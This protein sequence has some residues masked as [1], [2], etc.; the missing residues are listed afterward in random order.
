M[1]ARNKKVIWHSN[2]IKVVKVRISERRKVKIYLNEIQDE[3]VPSSIRRGK[4]EKD[5]DRTET[6][7]PARVQFQQVALNLSD[8][9]MDAPIDTGSEMEALAGFELSDKGALEDTQRPVTLI[10]AGRRRIKGGN[11]DVRVN[12]ILPMCKPDGSIVKYKCLRVCIYVADKGRKLIL[13][14]PLFLRCNL[15]V[16]PGM[17]WLMQVPRFVHRKPHYENGKP[18]SV[19]HVDL[20][21]VQPP[22]QSI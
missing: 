14:F 8:K 6:I 7:F 16:V 18:Q 3:V 11:Q 12:L 21:Q 15:C 17:P 22:E 1:R 19:H 2:I 4:S 5:T 10:W 20:V 13:G 9:D